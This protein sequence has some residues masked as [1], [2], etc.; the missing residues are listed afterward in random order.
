MP[1]STFRN[2]FFTAIACVFLVQ[3]QS[4]I[5][6][7]YF[8]YHRINQAQDAISFLANM[9]F[10][11]A[12]VYMNIN[13]WENNVEISTQLAS[14]HDRQDLRFFNALS[15]RFQGGY[16]SETEFL[17]QQKKFDFFVNVFKEKI[18]TPPKIENYKPVFKNDFWIVYKLI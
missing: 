6:Y 3:A 12:K 10:Q 14:I 7:T 2:V 15:S 9:T 11:G 1:A 5:R 13:D 16:T 8:N 17:A 18:N 4:H